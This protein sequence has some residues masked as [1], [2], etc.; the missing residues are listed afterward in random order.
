MPLRN[1]LN[2]ETD[3]EI[4]ILILCGMAGLAAVGALVSY[5]MSVMDE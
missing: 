4:A 3:M 1:I 2:W 5:L